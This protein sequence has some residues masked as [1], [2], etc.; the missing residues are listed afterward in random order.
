MTN[1]TQTSTQD[2]D[3]KFT[4]NSPLS[5]IPGLTRDLGLAANYEVPALRRALKEVPLG[6]KGG[7]D[8]MTIKKSLLGD[9]HA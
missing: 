8:G 3:R 7:L 5:V 6:C 9:I 2:L 4:I 1:Q